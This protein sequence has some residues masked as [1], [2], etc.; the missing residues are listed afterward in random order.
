LL[1]CWHAQRLLLARHDVTETTVPDTAFAKDYAMITRRIL[2]AAA[3]VLLGSAATASAQ[4]DPYAFGYSTFGQG[5]Y[6]YGHASTAEE[7]FQRGMADVIRSK[8]AANLMNSEASKN[9]EEGRKK[10]IENRQLWTQTYFEMQQM[11]RQYRDA[12]AGPKPSSEDLYRYAKDRAPD[13]LSPSELDP[14]T[15]AIDWPMALQE[16]AFAEQRKQMEE[17]FA[18]R[19]T[20]EGTANPDTYFAI[21][22]TGQ[23]M[24]AE[25][26][27]RI[28]DYHPNLYL[29]AK[30][31]IQGLLYEST[32]P[33]SA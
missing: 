14:L 22:R 18:K 31:F 20:A 16:P 19:M 23:E 17:L 3:F 29:Q 28:G 6:G 2:T 1:A 4:F 10:Y 15:A 5:G 27:S 24:E 7:G 8:G 9:W 30:R 21:T 25:L 12:K 32:L 26:K 33:P 13:R 11:N